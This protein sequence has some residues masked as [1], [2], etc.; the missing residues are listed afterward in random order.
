MQ[1]LENGLL[2]TVSNVMSAIRVEEQTKKKTF[3]N[4]IV[5]V[6]FGWR[7][8]RNTPEKAITYGDGSPIDPEDIQGAAKIMEEI[9]VAFK[10]QEGLFCHKSPFFFLIPTEIYS[11]V[12]YF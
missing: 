10:W 6:F 7:D 3:F 1:W 12:T 9:S 2:R 8:S 4:S 11:K 5:A